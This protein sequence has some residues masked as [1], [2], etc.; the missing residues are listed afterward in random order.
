[1]AKRHG[2]SISAVFRDAYISGAKGRDKAARVRHAMQGNLGLTSNSNLHSAYTVDKIGPSLSDEHNEANSKWPTETI[3]AHLE[4]PLKRLGARG[5]TIACCQVATFTVLSSSR[6][7]FRSWSATPIIA[8]T[9]S[10]SSTRNSS[11][12]TLLIQ[13][14]SLTNS[15]IFLTSRAPG[16]R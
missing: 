16:G 15:T 14:L 12:G 13:R 6:N 2:W 7:V 10:P 5:T 4:A 3:K 9:I 1:M 11:L 8:Q